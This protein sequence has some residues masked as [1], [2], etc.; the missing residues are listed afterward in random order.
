MV[1][2]LQIAHNSR[3]TPRSSVKRE[4]KH[5][6]PKALYEASM[7]SYPSPPPDSYV[8]HPN[9]STTPS[10]SDK[11]SPLSQPTPS[12]QSSTLF[13][14][15][16]PRPVSPIRL[17]PPPRPSRSHTPQH[18]VILAPGVT[19]NSDYKYLDPSY[20]HSNSS[21]W[22]TYPAPQ[23]VSRHSVESQ[24]D[25]SMHDSSSCK[26]TPRGVDMKND[27]NMT[28]DEMSKPMS[29]AEAVDTPTEEEADLGGVQIVHS[30]E[31]ESPVSHYLEGLTQQFEGYF[32]DIPQTEAEARCHIET[33]RD[34]KRES[35]RSRNAKDLE[36]ALDMSVFTWTS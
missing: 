19:G 24:Q 4:E 18:L 23:P 12:P 16:S 35:C 22:D 5:E 15:H 8:Q 14:Q 1:P 30:Y 9:R 6:Y 31:S 21:K 13:N 17:S 26:Y 7:S 3:R 36:V 20:S 29:P 2:E 27:A 25:A 11:Y 28:Y 34:E 32:L 33:I 10:L